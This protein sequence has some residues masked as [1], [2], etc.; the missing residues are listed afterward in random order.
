MQ[1][2]GYQ[3]PVG[4]GEKLFIGNLPYNA[5]EA[6]IFNY[7]APFGRIL[8]VYCLGPNKSRSG[9][10]C[11]FVRYAD[12]A[13]AATA[14][15][16]LD[17]RV[18]LRP[19]DAPD[20]L[21]QVRPARSQGMNSE[22]SPSCGLR[23]VSPVAC[24]DRA[25]K[26][27]VGNLPADTNAEELNDFF[28]ASEIPIREKDT[29]IL[30]RRGS[31]NN[32]VCAFVFVT[33]VDFANRAIELMDAKM[34]I[35]PHEGVVK[36]RVAKETSQLAVPVSKRS[37]AHS[38]PILTD[39]SAYGTG[40]YLLPAPSHVNWKDPSIKTY[41]HY[42]FMPQSMSYGPMDVIPGSEPWR[43]NGIYSLPSATYSH[44]SMGQ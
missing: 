25:V 28:I 33:S 31:Q 1:H 16:Q 40:H 42:M 17:G 11:A 9:Q 8:E 24:P 6:E 35:R 12:S 44:P 34:S 7:F 36:V 2:T 37:R 22:S 10:A 21:M 32:A 19:H 23:D 5:L 20:L 13:S 18:S 41:H 15:E 30:S 14:V 26:L 3:D 43:N 38:D 29:F 4:G 39:P 27:F